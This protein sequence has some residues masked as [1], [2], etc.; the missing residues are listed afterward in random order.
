MLRLVIVLLFLII[1]LL[2]SLPIM[3]VLAVYGLFNKE[4]SVLAMQ[5]VIQWAFSAIVRLS[6]V[7]MTVTGYEAPP[8]G[9]AVIYVANHRG[10]FDVIA[11]YTI[12][13][14]RATMISKASLKWVPFLNLNMMFIRCLFL[15]RKDPRKGIAMVKSAG[16]LIKSG[17][18]I[19]I[20]PEGTRCHSEDPRELL[21]FHDGIFAA[22]QRAGCRVVPV[23]VTKTDD[24]LENHFPKIKPA[25]V[26]FAFGKPVTLKELPKEY[27]RHPGEYFR[28]EVI[29][30][31]GGG[32][33]E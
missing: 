15:D 25:D 11:G 22:A 2:L 8:E 28:G 20:F 10:F 7:K 24:V 29:A 16:E 1:Y 3:G 13:R 17:T 32:K 5:R 19:L 27:R 21:P 12:F 33:E 26:T 30:L 31:L 18:S 6:G 14:E 4:K 23:A 9:E